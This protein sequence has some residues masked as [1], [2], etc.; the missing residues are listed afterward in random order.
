MRRKMACAGS[1]ERG[2]YNLTA[3]SLS[4]GNDGIVLPSYSQPVKSRCFGLGEWNEHIMQAPDPAMT[5]SAERK[6][7][8]MTPRRRGVGKMR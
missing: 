7:P 2:N 3:I 5:F 1:S 4:P 6:R 8:M